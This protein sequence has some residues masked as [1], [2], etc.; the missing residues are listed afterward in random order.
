MA[1]ES[2]QITERVVTNYVTRRETIREVVYRNRD[3]I[4]NVVPEQNQLSQGWVYAHN[5]TV[6]ILPIDYNLASNPAPSSVSD[7][8]ALDIVAQ[9]Y[10]IANENRE[11]LINLQNWV[12]QQQE[13]R[14]RA[15]EERNNSSD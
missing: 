14:Q 9:N 12:R 8:D 5:Q 7:R 4:R 1:E 6:R 13:I 2:A 3:V 15:E 10:R 11:Q